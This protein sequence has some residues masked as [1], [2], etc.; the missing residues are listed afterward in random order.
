MYSAMCFQAG[1][2]ILLLIDR[3]RMPCLATFMRVMGDGG[4]HL[5]AAGLGA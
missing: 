5:R 2:H 1:M 3:R 4:E